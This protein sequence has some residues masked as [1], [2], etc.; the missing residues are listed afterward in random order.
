[1]TLQKKRDELAAA[2]HLIQAKYD[3]GIPFFTK[4]Q[5]RDVVRQLDAITQQLQEGNHDQAVAISITGLDGL[6]IQFPVDTGKVYVNYEPP[7]G[8]VCIMYEYYYLQPASLL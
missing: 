2:Q 6:A 5:F 8:G 1:M 3:A 7:E 4:D